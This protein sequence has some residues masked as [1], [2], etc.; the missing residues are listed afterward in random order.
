MKPLDDKKII[1][2]NS[3]LEQELEKER[4]EWKEKVIELIK[5]MSDNKKLSEAQI[6]QLSYRQQVQEK[7]ATYRILVEK[8]QGMLETQMTS[9]FRDYCLSYDIKLSSAEKNSFV[10]ADCNALKQQVNM[11]KTQISYFE[12]CVKTLDNFGFAVRNKLEILSQQL[13]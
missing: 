7:L 4:A 12:E 8:R 6:Y 9:R 1:E 11:I 2:Q 10:S 3:I 5:M 13:I